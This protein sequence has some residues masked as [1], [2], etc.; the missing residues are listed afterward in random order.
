VGVESN[1]ICTGLYGCFYG[2]RWNVGINFSCIV[3]FL[4][5]VKLVRLVI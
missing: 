5:F 3:V 2:Y 4:L 1:E